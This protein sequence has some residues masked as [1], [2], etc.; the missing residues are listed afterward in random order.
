MTPTQPQRILKADA[1]RTL[2]SKVAFNYEDINKRCAENVENARRRTEQMIE[3]VRAEAVE[4]RERAFA[5]GLA[6]GRDEGVRDLESE[7]QD[8]AMRLAEEIAAERL[9]TTLPAMIEAVEAVRR[10]R[11]QWLAEWESA[12]VH[13]SIAV[14]ERILRRQLELKPESVTRMMAETLQLATGNLAIRVR[15]HP[16]DVACLGDQAADFVHSM[17]SCAEAAIVPDEKVTRG[18]CVVESQHG[19]I[20][21]RI[22]TQLTRIAEELL[23]SAD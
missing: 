3:E 9:S 14:A 20:D 4:I 5:E 1:V 11:E 17:A 7:I 22:E 6:A 15:L 23:Q 13:L 16:D 2:G 21:A 12:A 18:G 8:R 10:Q 19:T